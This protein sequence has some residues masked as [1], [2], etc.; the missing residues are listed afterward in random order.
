MTFNVFHAEIALFI[1]HFMVLVKFSV[2]A[3][4]KPPEIACGAFF[5]NSMP[6]AE[7]VT[8]TNGSIVVLLLAITGSPKRRHRGGAHPCATRPVN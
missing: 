2:G 6:L 3:S 4:N 7:P 8:L 5:M 1:Y